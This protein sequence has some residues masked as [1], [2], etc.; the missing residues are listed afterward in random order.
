MMRSGLIRG[1]S[2]VQTVYD[3]FAVAPLGAGVVD[4]TA[5]STLVTGYFTGQELKNLVEFFLVDSP[6]HPGEYFPRASG[7]RFRYDPSRPQFDVVTAIEMGDLDR[8]YRAI[9]ISGKD[10]RLYS[11]TCP[12]MLAMIL[13]AIPKYTKGKLPLVAKNKDGQPLTSKV[14]AL[15]DPRSGTPDLLAPTG[16]MDRTSVATAPEKGAV[17]E[18]KE[19]QAIMDHLRALPVKTAGELP[20]IPV[21]ERAAE[22]RAI[23]AG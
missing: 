11:L 8:G 23:K 2:G 14:E 7:M 4:T 10:A 15:N 22:V 13:I 20:M 6:A 5:G 3:V 18:I 1:K 12:L 9:D 17:R 16:T 21:D 19:W